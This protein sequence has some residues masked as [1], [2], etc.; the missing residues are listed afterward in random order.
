MA[1]VLREYHAQEPGATDTVQA[2]IEKELRDNP[3]TDHKVK[4]IL[5]LLWLKR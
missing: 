2:V 4:H 1:Q 5:S 3:S